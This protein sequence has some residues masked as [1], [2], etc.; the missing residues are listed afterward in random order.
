MEAKEPPV[1]SLSE[2]ALEKIQAIRELGAS[3]TNGP[4]P[5]IGTQPP[6]TFVFI[7]MTV[8]LV[9]VSYVILGFGSY[10]EIRRN[11]SH[12]RCDPSISPF[13]AF[14]G[15]DLKETLNFCVGQVVAE[16]SDT[17]LNPLYWAIGGIQSTV[18][19]AFGVVRSIDSS[20][21]GLL[22]GF[23]DFVINFVNSFRLLGTRVRM[24]FIRMK[25]IFA[26]IYGIF[27][28]FTYASISAITFGYNLTCNPLVVFIAGI[29][30]ADVCCFAPETRIAM[31]AGMHQPICNCRIGQRLA[32]GGT[33]TSVFRFAGATVPM[34]SLHQEGGGD[35]V[36]SGNHAL[37]DGSG[38]WI[39]ARD[40][41]GSVQT[42]SLPEIWCLSTT[43]NRIHVVTA[44]NPKRQMV[45]TDYEESNEPEVAAEAQV[46]AEK[47]LGQIPGPP[48]TDYSLGLDPRL[49]VR[50][51]N[52]A[53]TQLKDVTLGSRL[54]NG[55]TVVGIVREICED[56]R[57][58]P[59]GWLVSA[60]QLMRAD[61]QWNR[62]GRFLS[63]ADTKP[64]EL[65]HLFL[66]KNEPFLVIGC[67][68]TKG[69]IWWV[70]DYQE[71]QGA[72]TQNPYD[73]ALGLWP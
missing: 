38:R 16:H 56:I 46:A 63:V 21:R 8:A 71:W 61:G 67:S 64:Q 70:R 53:L 22:K 60:A 27:V 25:D 3:L 36:V 6:G 29:A 51:S 28:A 23:T 58:T 48:V 73:R 42:A 10:Q 49:C 66:D 7:M 52:G 39:A 54:Q 12:Y 44:A 30:G 41:P 37:M 33:I 13:A 9:F 62:A 32:D 20:V 34:V 43:T 47:A 35:I 50:L 11:W 5:E 72:E 17:V 1:A 59:G 69:E 26:R 14:Y 19:G 24:A 57:Q 2:D 45:F 65:C 68:L 31:D 18:D 15:H 40:W 55:A 4:K